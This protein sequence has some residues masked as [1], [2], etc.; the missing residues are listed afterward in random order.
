MEQLLNLKEELAKLFAE[1]QSCR[2]T[3]NGEPK[4]SVDTEDAK[5]LSRAREILLHEASLD[6]TSLYHLGIL[7]QHSLE[8]GDYLIAKR[9][10]ERSAKEGEQKA[11]GLIA[12][13]EDRHQVS[14]GKKQKWGTQFQRNKEGYLELLPMLTDD[15]SGITDEIRRAN[16][17]MTKVEMR[18]YIAREN[19]R[20]ESQ[21][22][23]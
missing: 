21:R 9:L 16:N 18:A 13:A 5:R 23:I 3:S 8:S 19:A 4:Y 6:A 1:D 7:F 17:I 15:E 2:L 12:C 14:L 22:S 20:S 11:R 10:F